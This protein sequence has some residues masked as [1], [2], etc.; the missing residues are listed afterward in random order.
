METGEPG[1][2]QRVAVVGSGISGLSAALRL[3]SA[4]YAVE[5]IERDDV[6]GGRFG[7]GTLGDKTI[8][9]GGKNIGHKYTAF[10]EFVAELGQEQVYEPFGINTSQVKDNKVVT[11]D[12]SRRLRSLRRLWDLGSAR[13][14]C[15]LGAMAARIHADDTHRFL[16]ST[17]FARLARKYD[18]KPLEAHFGPDI[19]RNLLRAL[20][21]RTNGAEPDE[22][23]LGTFGTNLCMLLDT[24]DQLQTGIQPVLDAFDE[25][26]PSRLGARVEGLV[27]RDGRLVG[28]RIAERGEKAKEHPYDGVVVAAPAHATSEIVSGELPELSKRLSEVRYFPSTVALVEYDKPVFTREARA[29]VMRDGPCSNAGAYG[30]ESRHIVRY[31]FSGRH[32]RVAD[33]SADQIEEWLGGAEKRLA[34]SL[35]TGPM[36]RVAMAYR[37]WPRAYCAYVPFHGEFLTDVAEAAG[38]VSGLELAGDYLSG[39]SLEACC[40]SGNAAA[41]RLAAGLGTS[42]AAATGTAANG[43][44]TTA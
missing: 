25:R 35:S 27:I 42:R 43:T 13:D 34:E 29:L 26:V 5:V 19:M 4:G 24:Y 22:V 10:R 3:T 31:T 36:K 17:Y 18:H 44:G 16:G 37:H 12:S 30:T 14:L 21:V 15:R 33:P 32:A 38:G 28:L 40:R 20:V 11:L 1:K 41:D 8:M 23:Y 39:A 6:L 9:M 2:Q 7:V